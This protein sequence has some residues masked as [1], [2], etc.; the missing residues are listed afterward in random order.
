MQQMHNVFYVLKSRCMF[1]GD[2]R[3][4][5]GT[6]NEE[7]MCNDGSDKRTTRFCFTLF[8]RF[9]IIDFIVDDELKVFVQQRVDQCGVGYTLS[10]CHEKTDY[11]RS[12]SRSRTKQFT[13]SH[14]KAP[15]HSAACTACSHRSRSKSDYYRENTFVQSKECESRPPKTAI[16]ITD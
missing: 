11:T 10:I 14:T 3:C 7:A 1:A 5:G 2:G 6:A 13:R 15:I 4:D 16:C 9:D 12:W 8:W